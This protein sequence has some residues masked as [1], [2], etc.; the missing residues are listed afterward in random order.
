MPFAM[1]LLYEW[2][3]TVMWEYKD[4]QLCVVGI[5]AMRSYSEISTCDL[6]LE[7]STSGFWPRIR[8]QEFWPRSFGIV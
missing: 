7:D 4:I 5:V 2:L 3:G 6:G 8:P 1:L